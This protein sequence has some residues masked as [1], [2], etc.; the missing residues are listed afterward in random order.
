M[1]TDYR[2]TPAIPFAQLF[3]GRLEKYGVY[4]TIRSDSTEQ[5]RYLVGRDG[6]LEAYREENGNSSFAR[7]CFAPIPWA[8]LDAL[9]EEFEV[10][11]VCE[12]DPRYWGFATEKEWHDWQDQ[13]ANEE[14][15]HLYDELVRYVRKEPNDL[16]PGTVGMLMAE[17]AAA[18][19]ASDESLMAPQNRHRLLE[20]V[21]AIYDRDHTIA[22]TLT[23]KNL[24]AVQLMAARISELPHA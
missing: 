1:S 14:E 9:V 3:D 19:V 18:L 11:L 5:I 7:P 2:S 8:V 17:I 13:L 16:R 20:A 24:A 23:K 12:H 10:E 4:E 22:I 6:V 21:K 15:D